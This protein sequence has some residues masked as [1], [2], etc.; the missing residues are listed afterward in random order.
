[1]NKNNIAL[2]MTTIKLF[3]IKNKQKSIIAGKFK[4]IQ[5]IAIDAATHKIYRWLIQVSLALT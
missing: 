2:E 4:K 3:C 5:E 1:M